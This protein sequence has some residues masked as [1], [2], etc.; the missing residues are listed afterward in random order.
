MNEF[1]RNIKDGYL[2]LIIIPIVLI[3][4]LFLYMNYYGIDV[5]E[6]AP[7]LFASEVALLPSLRQ[8]I[9]FLWVFILLLNLLFFFLKF[10]RQRYAQSF[11]YLFMRT[12]AV[13]L[14]FYINLTVYPKFTGKPENFQKEKRFY[15]NE[16]KNSSYIEKDG[17][18]KL[19]I[20]HNSVSY[21]PIYEHGLQCQFI[22]DESDTL[23]NPINNHRFLGV[24]NQLTKNGYEICK[25]QLRIKKI[26]TKFYYVCFEQWEC[27]SYEDKNQTK[28]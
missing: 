9:Y 26:E 5:L 15:E 19:T 27:E 6:P 4:I 16:I 28:K 12:M 13:S 17:L 10:S 14:A 2:S 18:G 23:L 7:Q 20:L 8:L 24:H 25:S 22:Y 3:T 21:E 1:I 11:A